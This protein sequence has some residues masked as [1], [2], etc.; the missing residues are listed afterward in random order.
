MTDIYATIT[1]ENQKDTIL[2]SDIDRSDQ[3]D[4]VMDTSRFP[5]IF[6]LI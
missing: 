2:A 3:L 6:F 5:W 4:S 1:L